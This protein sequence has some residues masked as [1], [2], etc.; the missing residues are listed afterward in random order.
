MRVACADSDAL[1]KLC[2]VTASLFDSLFDSLE[3]AL[4]WVLEC[5]LLAL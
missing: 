4:E 2:N 5:A 1:I 3:L